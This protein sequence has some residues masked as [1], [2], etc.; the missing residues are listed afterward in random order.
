VYNALEEG[1]NVASLATSILG[2]VVWAL[3]RSNMYSVQLHKIAMQD[4]ITTNLEAIPA[5]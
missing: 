3:G 1:S 2:Q 4:I 5:L